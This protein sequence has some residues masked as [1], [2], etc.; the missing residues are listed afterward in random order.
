MFE[1]ILGVAAVVFVALLLPQVAA[2]EANLG[3]SITVNPGSKLTANQI[4]Q[5]AANAGFAGGDLETAI[6]IALAES[7]GDPN[8]IGDTAITT[9]GSV[10]LW[11]VNLH[12]HPEYD[13]LKLHDPQYNANAAYAIYSAAGSDFAPWSTYKSGAYEA[14]LN[15]DGVAV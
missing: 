11:Q 15:T 2:M 5:V 7:G 12:W 14:H 13:Q 1:A 4:R 8:A 3:G 9:G 10:G 6:A